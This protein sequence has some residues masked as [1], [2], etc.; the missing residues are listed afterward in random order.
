M[1]GQLSIEKVELLL[2]FIQNL[3]AGADPKALKEPRVRSDQEFI[4]RN[5]VGA[6][7]GLALQWWRWI[8]F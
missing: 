4:F 2:E 5:T 7:A 1:V 6:A 3:N 8:R